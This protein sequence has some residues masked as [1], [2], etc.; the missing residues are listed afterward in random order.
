MKL[1]MKERD[2]LQ[3]LTGWSFE[4]VLEHVVAF[5]DQLDAR[6]RV[7]QHVDS[8]R[9]RQPLQRR[10]VHLEQ[11]GARLQVLGRPVVDARNYDGDAVLHAA[12]DREVEPLAGR[13][14]NKSI[15]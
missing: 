9:M 4:G 15:A 13:A 14:I 3:W 1:R 10:A 8:L 12:L 7:L 11:L 6:A 2:L 5:D